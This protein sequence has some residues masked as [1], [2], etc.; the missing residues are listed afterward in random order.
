MM[1][2][3]KGVTL[4]EAH[5]RLR[6][7]TTFGAMMVRLGD[8]DGLV[9]GVSQHYPVTI[10]QALQVIQT[11]PNV[12]RVAGLFALVLRDDVYFLADPL[13]NIDPTAEELAE[14]ALLSAEEV[15]RFQI[16]PR[17][18]MIS[19]SNFGSVKHPLADKVRRATEM[20]RRRAPG[21]VVDGEMQADTAVS[22]E[23]LAECYPFSALQGGANVLIFPDLQSANA[24]YKLVLR[25]AGAEAIGPILLGLRKPVYLLQHGMEVKDIVSAAALAVVEA[26]E[27]AGEGVRRAV[28]APFAAR[29]AV[30]VR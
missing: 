16:E 7:P 2:Q 26:Q 15:R 13:V 27:R 21:L 20:V 17:I 9:A 8:A 28:E 24:A 12:S 29:T 22:A 25:L 14:I 10:R 18:A 30:T 6:E 11:R 4:A 19:F 3:R 5:A 23:L 1:R